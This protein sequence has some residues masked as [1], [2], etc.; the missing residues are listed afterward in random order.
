MGESPTD[1]HHPK[2]LARF[3]NGT[4]RDGNNEKSRR[5]RMSQRAA[6]FHM[7]GRI[8][9]YSGQSIHQESKVSCQRVFSTESF[10]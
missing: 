6:S 9:S 4:G 10:V 8:V 5:D 1:I 3:T 2:H 7:R